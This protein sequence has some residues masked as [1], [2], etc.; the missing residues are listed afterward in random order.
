MLGKFNDWTQQ[1]ITW[2][3][4][5]KLCGIVY[6]ISAVCLAVSLIW[7]YWSEITE[8][9][10]KPFR[11]IRNCFRKKYVGYTEED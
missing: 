11:K 1:P 2:G 9:I 4:Y 8:F 7:Y 3:G 5:F 6:A 10:K